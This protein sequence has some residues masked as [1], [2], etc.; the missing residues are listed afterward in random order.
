MKVKTLRNYLIGLPEEFDE[1]FVKMTKH[2]FPKNDSL[3]RSVENIHGTIA[4][5]ET[6]EVFLLDEAG[7]DFFNSVSNDDYQNKTI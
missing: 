4:R 7:S 3:K 6:K 5:L 2:E 1:F